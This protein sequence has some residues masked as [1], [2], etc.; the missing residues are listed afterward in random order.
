MASKLHPLL[1]SSLPLLKSESIPL[2]R[3]IQRNNFSR[4]ESL[5]DFLQL[6]LEQRKQI[7]IKPNFPFNLPVRL[8]EKIEK[9]TLNDPI[10][11]QFVPVINES[12]ESFGTLEPIQDQKFRQSQKLLQKY[13]GRALLL[14]SGACAMHCRYCFRQ[15]FPYEREEKG[16]EKEIAHLAL[17]PTI[18]EIILSGGDP[19]SL[20]DG[21]I[22]RLFNDLEAIP[23]IRRIRFHTR[24]PIGIPERIDASF[25]SILRSSS[26]QIYFIIHSNH[27]IELDS[28][29]LARLKNIQTL[30][31]QILN[32]SVL[33]KGVNDDEMTL[34]LLCEKLVNNGILPYY[35]HLHDPVKGTGHFDVSKERGEELI[36][37]LQAHL[38]G[39]G[40]PHLV[41]EEPGKSSKTFIT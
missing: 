23:H 21:T 39:Y 38:S 20:S 13:N 11:K 14:A 15:N 26:K 25:L 16:F 32:Q 12:D 40:I 35:L 22:A 24:F 10:F 31:I 27:A 7:L 37:F 6:T 9:G 2:W 28:E 17:N 3:Q 18:S 29:V 33:L 1:M 19:L 8:A 4:I 30:G 34:L 5:L 41:R 36:Q